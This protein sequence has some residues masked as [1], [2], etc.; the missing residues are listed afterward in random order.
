M[1]AILAVVEEEDHPRVRRHILRDRQNPLE[2]LDDQSFIES[3]RL[4]KEAVLDLCGDLREDLQHQ[5]ARSRALP[6]TLQ[7]TAALKYYASG[8]F[9][10]GVG[11]V[12]GLGRMTVSHCIR[13][14]SR[15]LSLHS[16]RYI[17]FPVTLQEQQITKT[18]FN[19]RY[20]FPNCLGAIDG[21]LIPIISPT[22]GED[23]PAYVCR[24]GYHAINTQGICDSELIFTNAVV[25]WPGSSHD[26]F[27]WANCEL[28]ERFEQGQYGDSWLIGDSGYPLRPWL[29]VPFLNPENR[30]Q[31]RYNR[32][33]KTGRNTIERAYGLLKMRFRCLHK[34]GGCLMFSPSK[35]AKVIL[36]C[37]CLH[38]ICIRRRMPEPQVEVHEDGNDI[39][40]NLELDDNAPVNMNLRAEGVRVRQELTTNVFS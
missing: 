3:Y 34:S 23:E 9:L 8:M 31:E 10:R 29:L 32:H 22:A 27:I 17:N 11:E 7:V 21:T 25:R 36:A 15:A 12:L 4:S 28:A 30:A 38:N 1:A 39:D 13:D 2:T 20:G 24:K 26:A 33:H 19:D 6:V 35:C 37:M 16:Q 40:Q 18:G 14:V 5:T